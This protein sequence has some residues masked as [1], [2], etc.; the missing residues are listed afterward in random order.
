MNDILQKTKDII[1]PE[2]AHYFDE[3]SAAQK[4]VLTENLIRKGVNLA[5][6]STM[7]MDGSYIDYVPFS[8]I[9]NVFR[10]NPDIFFGGGI[11]ETSLASGGEELLGLENVAS[12]R[13]KIISQY[14]NYLDDVITFAENKYSDPLTLQRVELSISFLQKGMVS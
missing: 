3:L 9:Q 14:R 4:K 7:R 5:D 10:E 13:D 8:F 6:I 11:W 1:L 2:A 12:A